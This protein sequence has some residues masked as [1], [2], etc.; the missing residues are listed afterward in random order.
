MAN[1]V[2]APE[3][4]CNAICQALTGKMKKFEVLKYPLSLYGT[5]TLGTIPA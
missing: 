1:R 5:K 4:E 3:R 2:S